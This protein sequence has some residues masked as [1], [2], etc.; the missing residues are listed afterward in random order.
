MSSKKI[1]IIDDNIAILDSLRL[2]FDFEGFEVQTNTH[3]REIFQ[4][5]KEQNLPDLILLDVFLSGE[6]GREVCTKLKN[7]EITK[8]IVVILMSAGKNIQE[9]AMKAGADAFFPKPFDFDEMI[10]K[11]KEFTEAKKA[12]S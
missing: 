6:D 4:N 8:N 3:C 7:N 2:L 11:V 9:S 12:R 1:L 5:N 10:E